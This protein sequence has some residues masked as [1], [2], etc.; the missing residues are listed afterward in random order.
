MRPAAIW[1]S[2]ISPC[3]PLSCFCC[4]I[5]LSAWHFQSCFISFH[6]QTWLVWLRWNLVNFAGVHSDSSYEMRWPGTDCHQF[7]S[8]PG[9]LHLEV[10]EPAGPS[11][12]HH[13]QAWHSLSHSPSPIFLAIYFSCYPYQEKN[14]TNLAYQPDVL[15]RLR[16]DSVQNSSYVFTYKHSQWTVKRVRD[17]SWRLQNPEESTD[18]KVLCKTGPRSPPKCPIPFLIWTVLSLHN[19]WD[20]LGYAQEYPY[21]YKSC[22]GIFY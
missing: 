21:Y 1:V 3:L 19:I 20:S 7:K 15:S 14:L 4:L 17:A 6:L 11:V 16:C 2:I 13:S 10:E 22:K 5:A 8:D 12:L 9:Y 18:R